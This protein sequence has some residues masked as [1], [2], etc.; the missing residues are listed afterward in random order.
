MLSQVQQV[1]GAGVVLFP[2][3]LFDLT[4]EIEKTSDIKSV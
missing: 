4:K 1:K 2:G 3:T